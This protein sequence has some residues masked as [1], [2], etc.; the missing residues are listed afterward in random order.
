MPS[1]FSQ[2]N[3]HL[4]RERLLRNWRQNDLAEQ[5]GITSETVKRWENGRQQPSAYFRA[6]LCVLFG[7][8]AVDL[9]LLPDES[10]LIPS[11]GEH[12]G[13]WTVPYQRN[14]HFTGR[15]D[16]LEQLAQALSL[17][18][19]GDAM[20]TRQAA[21]SQPQAV[22]GLGGIGKTQIAL[23]YAYRAREQK[24]YTHF[25]WINAA[26][27]E[28]IITSFQTAAERLPNFPARDEKDQ[29]KL[30]MAILRWLEDCSEA[31]LLI[32]DNADELTLVQPY[33]PGQG[34][35]SIL[36]T[37]RASAVF[38][39]AHA[40]AVEQMGLI[41]GTR[42][43]LHRTG[44]LAASDE[45][46]N[47]AM[48]LVI[49]LDG[50]PLALDQAGAYVEETGCSFGDYLRLYETHRTTL[51]ARRGKQ[52]SNYPRS[53]ATTW[54]LSFE[55]IEQTHPA[56][57]ELLHL[58]AYLSPDHIPEELLTNG[59]AYWPA[60]LQEVVADPLRF[61]EML[62][63]LQA[64]SLVKRL[65]Q[66]H[67]LSLH[68]LVQVVQLDL[69]NLETQ[70]RW[71]ERVVCAV[72]ALFP[73]D[74]K[75]AVESW[76]QCLRYLEQVQACDTL[77]QQ[78]RLR[79]PEAIELLDRVGVY[80]REHASYSLAESLLQQALTMAEQQFGLEHLQV[81]SPLT[82]LGELFLEQGKYEQ[83]ERFLQRALH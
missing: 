45:E 61:N 21:L 40:L 55:Q 19:S 32:F 30:I 34:Q 42:F 79:L 39:L 53:V 5:L 60:V 12:A 64:F 75:D 23:E 73:A 37:T 3:Q 81:A 15:E 57:A 63:V 62:E 10:P 72:N 43:L 18:M 36:F 16:L 48:N 78:H 47:E 54:S 67:L 46:S 8:N 58:C 76:P 56:A 52:A 80:L 11:T 77:I 41:E 33:L 1:S 9:G 27:E 66:E 51:L 49:A 28:A 35:G 2:K 6:K 38:W 83:A 71:T 20:T 68:R 29:H 24:R 82:N 74:P 7:K 44:R 22:R 17:E 69:M 14:P 50:F 25:L 65:A 70:Q 26:S 4:R 31:W 59:A 13:L